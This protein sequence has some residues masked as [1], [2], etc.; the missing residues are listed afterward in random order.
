MGWFSI[1]CCVSAF[2]AYGYKMSLDGNWRFKPIAVPL[3]QISATETERVQ[4][5]RDV[6]LNDVSWST[7]R[8]PGYWDQPPGRW[9]WSNPNIPGGP[10]PDHDGEAWYRLHFTVPE[11][12]FP[13][14][15]APD[16]GK[17]YVAFLEFKGVS[18][19]ASVWLNGTF[20]GR[21]LGAFSP[22][23]LNV[24]SALLQSSTNLL[25]VRVR[26]KTLFHTKGAKNPNET[27][28]IPLGF[29]SESGGIGRSVNLHVSPRE[30]I[31]ELAVYPRQN[32]A[33]VEVLV[34]QAAIG[35]A[36]LE[37]E[38]LESKTGKRFYGPER[39]PVPSFP[40]SLPGLEIEM[41]RF[42][43]NQQPSPWSPESPVLYR[44]VARLVNSDGG[45]DI[46][47]VD[48]GFRS[49]AVRDGQFYLNGRP[50]FLL[51][52]G[53]PP[54]YE[55][56]SE[57]VARSHLTALKQAG[58]RMVRFAHEPPTEI[59]LR[60]CDEIGLLAWI[61]GG[62][63]AD[64]GPYD[65][66]N[67][68]L[69]DHATE[70]IVGVVRSYRN[71]PSAAIWSMGAGNC[72]SQT[73]PNARDKAAGVLSAMA[74]MVAHLDRPRAVFP[75]LNPAVI[76]EAT[77]NPTRVVLAE[78]DNRDFVKGAVED[79]QSSLGW[80]SGKVTE[81]AGFLNDVAA[82]RPD[83]SVPWVCSE[84]ETGY[85]TASQGLILRDP[86]EE[87]AARMR[88]GS[89]GDEKNELLGYQARRIKYLIEHARAIRDP[90]K[91][92]I[93][94]LFPFTSSNWFFN[95]LTPSA[96]EP[97]P[98]VKAIEQ[99]YQPVIVVLD[100]PRNHFYGGEIHPVDVTVVNDIADGGSPP[101]GILI[102]EVEGTNEKTNASQ[103]E[104]AP[105]PFASSISHRLPLTLPDDV[106]L[107]T[108]QVRV[109]L[110][111]GENTVAK[112]ETTIQIGSAKTCR[113]VQEDLK[114]DVRVYDPFGTLTPVLESFRMKPSAFEEIAQLETCAG[115]LIGADGFDDYVSRSW[116]IFEKWVEAGGR[117]LVFPQKR[118][119]NR[120]YFSGPYP[121]GYEIRRPEGWPTGIDRVNL[122]IEDHPLFAG[123][124]AGEMQQ[125]GNDR[126][127]AHEVFEKIEAEE[128]ERV[129]SLV[130]VVPSCEEVSWSDVV[131]E[132][133]IG[134]GAVILC[135]LE[136]VDKAATDPIAG[137][138]LRNSLEWVGGAARP[139]LAKLPSSSVPFLEPIVGNDSGEI[140]TTQA[141]LDPED[142]I[143]AIPASFA[144]FEATTC[145][146]I[147][148]SATHVGLL[149][150][151]EQTDKEW[152]VYYDVDDRF[153]HRKESRA[154]LE[155]RVYCLEP[156]QIRVDYDSSDSTLGSN[157]ARKP[158]LSQEV[159][160]TGVWKLL[161]FPLPDALFANLQPNSCDF[162]LATA[163]GRAIY[164]PIVLRKLPEKE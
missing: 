142:P 83:A 106:G 112:N 40:G 73:D 23:E 21:H 129:R 138:I 91:N 119:T 70:E 45:E 46:R 103:K 39:N 130:D 136:I 29:D 86:M 37:L 10:F 64:D 118:I 11:E 41:D 50:Y 156:S 127:V 132:I 57:E 54:H 8:V 144:P 65:F 18:A 113:P 36:T 114:E 149:P 100:L 89:P 68:A 120:W 92:R 95:P 6:N 159:L 87:A 143:R 5:F 108:A 75:S 53:S 116:P 20:V 1:Q 109:R 162:R 16:G 3:E 27:S 163:K 34:S 59:W 35:K 62:L 152:H 52:A 12:A 9:P 117:I 58:V 69:V 19:Q 82:I 43:P 94:G 123:I 79:W 126:V 22:F 139:I 72:R 60:L 131:L 102:C 137:L 98:I 78:S 51:G 150:L 15:A 7:I 24:T 99:S 33:T 55:N 28:Q 14:S 2:P 115:L 145:T 4:Q 125:W 141:G 66:A 25:A 90:S 84:I 153:W 71:H 76:R 26:D 88:I 48:F 32:S 63:S 77:D 96:M 13:S 97:K 104:I 148:G 42:P 134:E 146:D 110:V 122:L 61:E 74:N 93:A 56:P 107:M 17:G 111:S 140:S 154:E 158:T 105:V 133:K 67:R 124:G 101:S 80:Y 161:V 85:S 155:V 121:G 38:I 31:A 128:P 44:L 164:G 49:F 135:Q 151:V 81:W 160:E 47:E 30:R 157:A 147:S